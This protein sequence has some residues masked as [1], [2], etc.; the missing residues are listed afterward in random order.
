MTLRDT[1]AF[2]SFSVDDPEKARRF[3]GQT[4]GLDI[5]DAQMDG[6]LELHLDGGPPVM[7]YPKGKEHEPA[8]FTVLNFQVSNIDTTVDELNRSG[9]Q[10]ER[11][12]L[13][14]GT[15]DAKGIHRDDQGPPIAWFKDPAGNVLSVLEASR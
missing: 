6:L 14:G 11:Y 12:N 10:M 1:R 8:S 5:R 2:S 9:I 13:G 3:Y 7:I 15:G 4:L